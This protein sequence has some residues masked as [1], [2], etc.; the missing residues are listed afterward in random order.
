MKVSQPNIQIAGAGSIGTAIGNTLARAGHQ[1]SLFTIEQQVAKAINERHTNLDY[2]PN[3]PLSEK[4][5]ATM[6]V[7]ELRK[8]DFLFLAIPSII[9]VDFVL[10]NKEH[11]KNDAVLV[12]LAKG[13]GCGEMTITSCLEKMLPN[14]VCTM[15]G[16]T[17]A[18]EI[19]NASP[20]A[21]ITASTHF[22]C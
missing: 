13:F 1:I 12:N 11:I 14:P 21:I 3:A 15:K 4:L 16:P 2:F 8:A 20:T 5:T 6:D 17:F 19:M 7:K 18:R 22:Q 9:T 10:Q